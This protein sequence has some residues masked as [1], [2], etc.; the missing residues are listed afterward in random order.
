MAT[1]LQKEKA[2]PFA[3][4]PR[5][6]GAAGARFVKASDRIVRI[7]V[8]GRTL[9]KLGA[10]IAHYGDIKFN[11]L[12]PL[13]AKGISEKLLRMVTPLV[14]VEG[15]GTVYCARQGWR[16]RIVT[17]TGGTVNVAAEELLAF[18]DSL[19]F[20]VFM[21]GVGISVASGGIFAVKL[22]GTGSL[23]IAVHGDPMVLP[24]TA[25]NDL[26]TDPH[27]T[28]AWTDGLVP[29]LSTDL[30][31]RSLIGKGGGEAFEMHFAGTGEVVVQ[32]SEDKAKFTYK[33]IKALI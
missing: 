3:D 24:V 15:K 27:A 26:R 8:D 32:P 13:K 22:S 31:W 21:V 4:F 17:L 2:S 7:N 20:D 12:P 11:R 25:E 14:S 5:D 19:A 18:E 33:K 9:V 30:S 16:V 1:E 6:T 10:G 29:T 28:V 23:A